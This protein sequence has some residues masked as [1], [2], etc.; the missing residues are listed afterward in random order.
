MRVRFESFDSILAPEAKEKI[1]Y[2]IA[3]FELNGR[4]FI[5]LQELEKACVAVPGS[6][7]GV[8]AFERQ[9]QNMWTAKARSNL[10]S[11]EAASIKLIERSRQFGR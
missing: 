3:A 6:G 10:R 4:N 5:H 11:M 8:E 2:Q 7:R 9:S 1:S